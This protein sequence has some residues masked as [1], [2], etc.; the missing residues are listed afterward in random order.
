MYV[1]DE[2]LEI[3]FLNDGKL[4]RIDGP[5]DDAKNPSKFLGQELTLNESGEF[6][7]TATYVVFNVADILYAQA[8][9]VFKLV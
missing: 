7:G 1:S 8:E 9:S 4:Y 2:D 3:T 5:L 6:V